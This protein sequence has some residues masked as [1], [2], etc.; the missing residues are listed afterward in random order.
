MAA[1]MRHER[2][3]TKSGRSREASQT[4]TEGNEDDVK[5]DINLNDEKEKL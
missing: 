1:E 3:G 2:R 5:L 4:I